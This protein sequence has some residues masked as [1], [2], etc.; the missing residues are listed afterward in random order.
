[1]RMVDYLKKKGVDPETLEKY[2]PIEEVL[3]KEIEVLGFEVRQSRF[4]DRPYAVIDI[5]LNG[6]AMKIATSASHV[7][8]CLHECKE[9]LPLTC[10]LVR[11]DRKIVV[12]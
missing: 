4:S 9:G 8:Y 10:T 3:N 1:M 6:S 11:D 2:T 7:L 12:R 5:R